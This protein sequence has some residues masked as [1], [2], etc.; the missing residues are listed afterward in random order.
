M[1]TFWYVPRIS[2]RL[3]SNAASSSASLQHEGSAPCTGLETLAS[4]LFEG[5]GVVASSTIG[6]SGSPCLPEL[7]WHPTMS[8]TLIKPRRTLARIIKLYPTVRNRRRGADD[9]DRARRGHIPMSVP[10]QTMAPLSSVAASLLAMRSPPWD[11]ISSTKRRG[12]SPDANAKS[13]RA[14]RG[15]ACLASPVRDV[16]RA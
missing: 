11:A 2:T 14:G 13:W 4:L 12:T 8:D 6:A 3:P 7:L 9:T 1:F 16:P 15:E 10:M 5:L